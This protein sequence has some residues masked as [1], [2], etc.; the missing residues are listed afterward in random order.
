MN[1][2]I[3]APTAFTTSKK[4]PGHPFDMRMDTWKKKKSSIID[5]LEERGSILGRIPYFLALPTLS[6]EGRFTSFTW[7]FWYVL[8]NRKALRSWEWDRG[9]PHTRLTLRWQSYL[10]RDS[11]PKPPVLSYMLHSLGYLASLGNLANTA[12]QGHNQKNNEN[13]NWNSRKCTQ[14]FT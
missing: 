10:C 2:L 8:V 6:C 3:H 9:W 7:Q 4:E 5:P 12:S 14:V 13:C 1:G 11:N